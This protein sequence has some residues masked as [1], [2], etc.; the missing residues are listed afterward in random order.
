[1]Q[2]QGKLLLRVRRLLLSAE[3]I[4]RVVVGL[5]DKLS[6]QADSEETEITET[7]RDLDYISDQINMY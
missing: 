3:L 7:G 2:S 6:C 5:L 1:M 4:F